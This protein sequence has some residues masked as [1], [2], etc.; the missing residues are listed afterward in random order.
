M[1]TYRNINGLPIIRSCFNCKHFQ[2]IDGMDKMGYCQKNRIYFA[3]T[4]KKTVFVIVKSFYLCDNHSLTNEEELAR[5]QE[6]LNLR[7]VLKKKGDF[8]V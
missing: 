7:D 5:E 3:Y 6:P 4:L 2:P 8:D 1:K